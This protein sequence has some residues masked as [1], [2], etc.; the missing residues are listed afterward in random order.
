MQHAPLPPSGSPI[1]VECNGAPRMWEGL[2]NL[3]TDDT[4]EGEAVHWLCESA[5]TTGPFSLLDAAGIVAPNGVIITDEM[6][7]AA[8]MYV[9]EVSKGQG[10]LHVEERVDMPEIHIHCWGTPDAWRFNSY[11]QHLTIYDF[12]YGH[13]SVDA[14]ENWQLICYALGILRKLT[15]NNPMSDMFTITVE[16]VI[17]Q[18]RCYYDHRGPVKTWTI[19][20]WELR[21]YVNKLHMAAEQAYT[22]NPSLKCGE[23]CRDCN[24][25][26]KCPALM[27]AG[28]ELSD[29]AGRAYYHNGTPE[30]I[31]Y[32]YRTLKRASELLKARLEAI[33]QEAMTR[34]QSGSFIP[35]LAIE[36][37]LSRNKW[38][39]PDDQVISMC[40][41][42]GVDV[43]KTTAITP[44]QAIAK[45]KKEGLDPAIIEGQYGRTQSSAKLVM[46]DNSRAKQLFSQEKIYDT[47]SN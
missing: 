34:L 39:Q 11:T 2:P 14:Y 35:G 37:P 7:D 8:V 42:L 41:M 10:D 27:Q 6:I 29:Y 3:E 4:R 32:E 9:Q 25:A 23:Y 43:S 20:N 12:K 44:T 17:V 30:G 40:N 5:L 47:T 18:P 16:F 36:H 1:W 28:A 33:E 31:E 45:F 21:A 38:L 19:R 15:N 24:A 26:S 13:R 22:N 46:D